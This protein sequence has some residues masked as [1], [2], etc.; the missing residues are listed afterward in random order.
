MANSGSPTL[1]TERTTLGRHPERGAHD[2]ETIAS[3]LDEGLICHVG[4]TAASHPVVIPT[5]YGRDG[6][7]LYIHGS[8][9]SSMLDTLA[10][11]V[12][13]CLTVT[14]LDGLVL[15]RSAFRHSL[16]YR[17]VMIF[18]TARSV[19]GA[20]KLRGLRVISEHIVRGRWEEMR[21]PDE[22]ELKASS[23]LRLDI[24]EASAKVR[25]GPP[26]DSKEDLG[27]AIWAGVLP[28][29]LVPQTPIADEQLPAGV[30]LPSYVREYRRGEAARA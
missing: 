3:I 19:A 4:F 10:G 25:T 15:A 24:E 30:E 16:N 14:L 18:G 11:G 27:R 5:A 28:L 12:R 9:A 2:F 17:S 22:G 7:R 26:V 20:E 13:C 21:A 8:A 29:A 6:R 1:E 23:V